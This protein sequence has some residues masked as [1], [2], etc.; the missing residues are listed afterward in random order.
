MPAQSATSFASW[1]H[2][3]SPRPDECSWRRERPGPSILRSR[4]SA[5]R[6]QRRPIQ[7]HSARGRDTP[8]CDAA[9][10]HAQA[11]PGDDPHGPSIDGKASICP[12]PSILNEYSTAARSAS[13][14]ST[15]LPVTVADFRACRRRVSQQQVVEVGTK[16]LEAAVRVRIAEASTRPS[17]EPQYTVFATV[18]RKPAASTR[19]GRLRL[20]ATY[21]RSADG[22]GQTVRPVGRA[23]DKSTRCPHDA[24]SPADACLRARRR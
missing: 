4:R 6:R 7:R 18:L 22:L 2:P 9:L 1:R 13:G 17:G 11:A 21:A 19:R 15:R 16:H 10:V 8:A 23:R 20:P 5:C 14:N 3:P 12:A 24:S